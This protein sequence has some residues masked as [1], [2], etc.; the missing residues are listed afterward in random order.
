MSKALEGQDIICIAPVD[1]EPI[2]NRAQQLMSRLPCSN[3]ILYLEPPV[4][5]LS[6][7]KDR[8]LWF[9]WLLWLRGP[10]QI[11]EN[12]FL[13][14]PPVVL[15]FGNKY[16]QINR[17]NQR[18]LLIFTRAVVR[19][20]GMKNI[21]LW[22][23]L[24]NCLELAR[25][26]DPSL[27]VYD[28]VD[29]HSE[30]SGL[31][32]KDVVLA[33]ERDLLGASQLV[34]ATARGLY[35]AKKP[36]CRQITLIPNAADIG[37][38]ALADSPATPVPPEVAGLPGPVLGF[39]GVLHHW[40]DLDLFAYLARKR[41]HW[42]LVLIGP[43]GPGIDA[44]VLEGLP[45]VHLLGRKT[46]EELPGYLKAFDVCLN[47]FKK[48][49]LT[50]RVSPLKLYEYLASGR[51]VVSVAMPGVLDFSNI[52]E[53]AGDYEGFLQGVERALK[54]ESPEK[55]RARLEVAAQ[56]SWQGRVEAM[57]NI[58]SDQMNKSGAGTK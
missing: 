43:L 17:F 27:L 2:W 48:N 41:P 8:S 39:I 21:L 26:L 36:F 19:R 24:P 37:H 22:T 11:T 7:L 51:P 10:R 1:W 23:Y 18:W 16:P 45:N 20:L 49:E 31:I 9:K 50:D 56:N 42:S 29:E 12:I 53:I 47:V 4:T 15:P 58:I 54:N 40:I 44:G 46:K 3:R 52:I 32:N 25:G 55:K 13:Y 28:C 5:L 38:F 33:L 35:E 57:M 6:A 30:F 14:S 34:F